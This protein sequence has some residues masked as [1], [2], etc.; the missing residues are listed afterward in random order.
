MTHFKLILRYAFSDLKKQKIRTIFAIIGVLIS[1]GL[2]TVILF[3]SDSISAS[4]VDYLTIEA[5]N[6]DSS[7]SVR[8]YTGEPEDRSSYFQF[9]PI[10]ETIQNT[11]NAIESFIP[12]MDVFGSVKNKETGEREWVGISAINFSLENEIEFGGFTEPDTGA[13][14]DLD[15]LPID[16]C[17]IYYGFNDAIK[18]SPHDVIELELQLTHGNN[19][20]SVI[21]NLTIDVIFD[22]N[23]KWP[24]RYRNRHLI[25]VDIKT[26]YEYFGYTEFNGRCSELILTLQQKSGLYDIRNIEGTKTVV[27]DIA[28]K[29]QMTCKV[30]FFPDIVH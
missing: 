15:E 30:L 6:Q 8:H 11:T 9:Q 20:L 13:R 12:R 18:Y 24:D 23:L 22:F 3:L 7:I 1:I 4:Y 19:N 10:I 28:G 17:A 25:V 27:K 5:G 16:H 29:I 26:L 2:L 21:K 14:L